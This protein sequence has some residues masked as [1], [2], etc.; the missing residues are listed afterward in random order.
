M[1]KGVDPLLGPQLLAILRAMGH[2]DEIAIVDANYPAETH[3]TRVVRM[4][5]HPAPAILN[6]V[7]SLLPLDATAGDAA[8]RPCPF[9]D[10]DRREPVFADFEAVI[11][12]YE[13][14]LRLASIAGDA[15]YQRVRDAYAVIASGE[16]RLYG[17]IVLRKGVI[18]P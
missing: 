6:A 8:F 13:P 7:L 3:G 5:G 9:G 12:R 11:V 18:G 14:G 2:G 17:N 4:D 1:L 10:C 16:R 15:F